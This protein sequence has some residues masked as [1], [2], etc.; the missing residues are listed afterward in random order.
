M[1]EANFIGR[2]APNDDGV[3]DD[4]DGAERVEEETQVSVRV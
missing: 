3:D 4:D 2:V 1:L